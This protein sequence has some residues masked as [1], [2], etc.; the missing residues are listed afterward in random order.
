ME[1]SSNLF[2]WFFGLEIV[3]L[4]QILWNFWFWSFTSTSRIDGESPYFQTKAIEKNRA[5]TYIYLSI[6]IFISIISQWYYIHEI[7]PCNGVYPCVFFLKSP[8]SGGHCGHHTNL[9]PQKALH[10][11]TQRCQDC[12]MHRKA[13]VLRCGYSRLR[14][15]SEVV[16]IYQHRWAVW[17]NYHLAMTNSSPW[18]IHPFYS[19]R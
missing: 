1:I 8:F 13:H 2:Q 17:M 6:L 7:S 3:V 4:T 15:I 10:A 16:L 19:E 18:K 12:L 9:R 5:Y 11:F 14:E